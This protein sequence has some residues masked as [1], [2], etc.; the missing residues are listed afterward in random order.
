MRVIPA[1][2]LIVHDPERGDPLPPEGRD[3]VDSSYWYRR[4]RDGDVT[5]VET[6]EP[7]PESPT[8]PATPKKGA[9]K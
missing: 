2:G 9:S 4:V 7:A 1:P 6:P 3:V 5:V 8:P